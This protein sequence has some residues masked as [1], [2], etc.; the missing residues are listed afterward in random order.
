MY[1]KVIFHKNH[2]IDFYENQP[3]KVQDKIDF[4]LDLVQNIEI[5]PTK[6]LKHIVGTDGLYEIRVKVGSNIFRIFCFFD[7]GKLVVLINGFIKKSQKTP[8]KE[9]RLAEKLMKEYHN[10]K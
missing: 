2:F 9:I 3:D 7:K 5:V 8:P 1:R 4:V 6:F 10:E